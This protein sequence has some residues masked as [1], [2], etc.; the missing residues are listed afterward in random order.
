MEHSYANKIVL[1]TGGTSG[2]GKATAIAFSEI[3]NVLIK[4]LTKLGLLKEDL[5]YHLVRA[6]KDQLT[7]AVLSDVGNKVARQVAQRIKPVQNSEFFFPK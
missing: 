7:F 3:M 6:S 5:D 2:I 4:I 1:I